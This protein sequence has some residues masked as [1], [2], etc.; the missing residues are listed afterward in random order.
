VSAGDHNSDCGST[1]SAVVAYGFPVSSGASGQR[2]AGN[3][4]TE[5]PGDGPGF[6]LR[7]QSRYADRKSGGAVSR[8]EEPISSRKFGLANAN[9]WVPMRAGQ[10]RD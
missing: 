4:E 7:V 6:G 5:I 3:P 9:G 1:R 10:R 2:Q 8:V